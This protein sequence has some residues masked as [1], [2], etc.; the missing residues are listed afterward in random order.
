MNK[1]T[2]IVFF[3]I[4]ASLP[5]S[6]Q[7]SSFQDELLDRLTGNWIMQGIIAGQE[8]THDLEISWILE[9]QYIQIKEISREKD[10]DGTA[11]YEALVIIGWDPKLENYACLWLDVTGGS[12]LDG[13][14]IGHAIRKGDELPFIFKIDSEN[15]FHNTFSYYRSD[16]TWQ[17]KMDSEKNGQFSNFAKVKLERK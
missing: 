2:W 13:N 5:I 10:P 7:Q 17:W 8:I 12:G 3:S 9:H 16:D 15:A 11:V 4:F 6:A 1:M 14:A